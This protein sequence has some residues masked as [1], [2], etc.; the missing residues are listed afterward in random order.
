MVCLPQLEEDP[1]SK[2]SNSNSNYEIQIRNLTKSTSRSSSNRRFSKFSPLFL[3]WSVVK[4]DRTSRPSPNRRFLRFQPA[5]PFRV[6]RLKI[7]CAIEITTVS[8]AKYR[9]VETIHRVAERNEIS[10]KQQNKNKNKNDKPQEWLPLTLPSWSAWMS[11]PTFTLI[12]V[13]PVA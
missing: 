3:F 2:N 9:Y 1:N 5:L 4:G 8:F 6:S 10:T 7:N 11:V 12:L 13:R